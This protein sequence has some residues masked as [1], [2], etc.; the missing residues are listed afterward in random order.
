[1]SVGINENKN[2]AQLHD[3][4]NAGHARNACSTNSAGKLTSSVR[5]T[6]PRRQD[7]RKGQRQQ[8]QIPYYFGGSPKIRGCLYLFSV[9]S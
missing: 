1:M 5:D 7:E 9:P 4:W 3:T 2:K 6:V 8:Q